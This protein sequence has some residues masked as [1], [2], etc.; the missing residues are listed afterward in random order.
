MTYGTRRRPLAIRVNAS[1]KLVP[2]DA[3]PPLVHPT[4]TL[5]RLLGVLGPV[6]GEQDG[7]EHRVPSAIRLLAEGALASAFIEAWR[8]RPAS[9]QGAL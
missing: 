2:G 9:T 3:G 7:P 6:D 1:V 5:D 8:W 4:Q